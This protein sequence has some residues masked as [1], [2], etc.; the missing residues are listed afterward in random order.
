MIV[1]VVLALWALV[2][3]FVFPVARGIGYL[4]THS[5]LRRNRLRAMATSGA[6]VGA[7]ALLLLALPLPHW[8]RAEGVIWVPEGAQVRAGADGFVRTIA[9][10]PGAL[11]SRGRPLVVAENFELASRIRVLEAQLRLLETRAHA[12]LQN[13]RVRWEITREEIKATREEL[14]HTRRLHRELTI[15][16]P[17]SG[18]FVL[19]VAAQDLPERYLRKGQEI[20]YVV[21]AAAVTARVLVSQDDI[22]L[23]RT[24]TR[25]VRVKLAGRMYET[26][27]ATVRRETPAASNS[28]SN[29]AMSSAGGGPAPLD[30][31]DTKNPKTLNTWFE[32][33]LELPATHAF[34]LG[35]HVH[36]RFEL[37]PE[38]LAWRIYRSVRQLFLQRF[39]I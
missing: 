24:R 9:V 32:F 4:L 15:L 36:A 25:E 30:P 8:I 37:G 11:V 39:T 1:G 31:Q 22:D 12:E 27:S 23:V 18:R 21:P 20:G 34:V 29:L 17:T 7:V 19:S 38:P 33:E 14:E 2:T 28:V 5:R 13:D 35:E 16:S 3:S 6:V 26:F 10:E